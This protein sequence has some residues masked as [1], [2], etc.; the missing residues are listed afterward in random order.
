MKRFCLIFLAALLAA[1]CEIPFEIKQEGEPK[2]YLQAV[3]DNSSVTV[4]YRKAVPI[5][6]QG[7]QELQ[8][9][10]VEILLNGTPLENKVREEVPNS[11]EAVFPQPLQANDVI[12]VS[13]RADG[14]ETVSGSTTVVPQPDVRDFSFDDVKVSDVEAKEVRLTLEHAPEEGEYYG[15]QIY[16]LTTTVYMD[17][18]ITE[19]IAF[20]TP[21]YLLTQADS[22]SFDLEDFMQVNYSLKIMGMSGDYRPLTLVTKKQFEGNTYKF[23]LNSFDSSILDSIRENMPDGETGMAGGGIISGDV[24]SQLPG[25]GEWDPS[26]IPISC[27]IQYYIYFYRLSQEA[28]LYAKAMY[29]SNFDFLSN[30]GLTPAN[31]TWSNVQ[32]GL[33]F[34]GAIRGGNPFGPVILEKTIQDFSE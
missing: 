10:K 31:F 33:G 32:G 8:G 16:S 34:V 7:S 6:H 21:G 4:T 22:G 12:S 23:Y 26:R 28:Y 30:M 18:S 20:L 25:E 15:I 3:A 1:S 2:I 13:L 5:N 24:G 9:E 17:Q 29:Q 11:V 14:V 19:D 27:T